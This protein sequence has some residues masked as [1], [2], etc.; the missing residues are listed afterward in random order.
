MRYQERAA[1]RPGF[2]G[3]GGNVTTMTV[4]DLISSI[5]IVDAEGKK[6]WG[7]SSVSSAPFSVMLKEGQSISDAVNEYIKPSSSLFLGAT[8]PRQ[9]LKPEAANGLGSSLI[10]S[11][12]I[13]N[14]K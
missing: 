1:G 9:I 5:E 10:T 11:K 14:K 2:F 3:G 12:G 7:T 6:L 13:V 8:F 4:T